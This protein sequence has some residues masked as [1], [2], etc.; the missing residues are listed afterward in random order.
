MKIAFASDHAGFE[1]KK[2]LMEWLETRRFIKY[3]ISALFPKRAWIIL[4]TLLSAAEAGQQ[5]LPITV[6]L[7]CGSGIVMAITRKQS[8]KHPCS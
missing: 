4:I 1:Y 6:I 5:I 7:I 2:E 8:N 3:L